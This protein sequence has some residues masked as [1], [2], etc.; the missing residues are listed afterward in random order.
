[1]KRSCFGVLR[2][3][4]KTSAFA[5]WTLSC[6][7]R[8]SSWFKARKGGQKVPVILQAREALLKLCFQVLGHPFLTAVEKVTDGLLSGGLHDGEHQIG[9]VDAGHLGVA[10]KFSHPHGGHAV[11]GAEEGIVKDVF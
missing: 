9:A 1:M 11:R 7:W 4:Q 10:G 5:V 6:S 3:T 2:P 8:T